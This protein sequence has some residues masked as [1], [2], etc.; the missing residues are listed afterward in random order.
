MLLDNGQ[1]SVIEEL[2]RMTVDAIVSLHEATSLLVLLVLERL[3]SGNNYLSEAFKEEVFKSLRYGEDKKLTRK[4]YQIVDMLGR[5]HSTQEIAS[6]LHCSPKTVNVHRANIKNKL[7]ISTNYQF[8][9]YCINK[10]N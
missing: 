1:G 5:G 7:G 10:V 6:L 3:E 9:R 2:C 4:E 8:I